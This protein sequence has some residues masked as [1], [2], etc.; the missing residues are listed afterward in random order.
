LVTDALKKLPALT[1]I[2]VTQ[3]GQRFSFKGK[4]TGR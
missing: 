3:E 1:E 4:V 2:G